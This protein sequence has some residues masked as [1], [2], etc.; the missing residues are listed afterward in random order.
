MFYKNKGNTDGHR[1]NCKICKNTQSK[2]IVSKKGLLYYCWK[3]MSQRCYNTRYR[4][5]KDWG[6]RGITVC[7]E[8]K[9]SF[10]AFK[11]WALSNGYKEG[12]TIDRIDNDKGYSP[13]NCRFVSRKVQ[14]NNKRFPKSNTGIP[15]VSYIRRINK[16]RVKVKGSYMGYTKT[17][18]EAIALLGGGLSGV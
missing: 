8:W 12:L 6:G 9:E 16:Y 15:C 1:N 7:S 17:I 4:Q 2:S 18:D 3:N 5:Y 14:N 13:D 11:N 10:T